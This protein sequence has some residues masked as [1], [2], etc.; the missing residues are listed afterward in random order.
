M[1]KRFI[2]GNLH[3]TTKPVLTAEDIKKMR[4]AV[5]KVTIHEQLQSYAVSLVEATREAAEIRCGAS[6]RALLS[7]L[8]CA[9]AIA[10]LADRD[11]CIPEDIATAGGLTLSHRIMLT[12]EAKMSHI[13][14][15]KIMEQII[16]KVKVS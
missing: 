9:Q 16:S 6:S 14:K 3:E 13:T 7:L 1:A 5:K 2:D 12:S 11:Y 10:F 4:E 15:E 8:R